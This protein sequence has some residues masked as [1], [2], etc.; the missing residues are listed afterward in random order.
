[1]LLLPEVQRSLE[2]SELRAFGARRAG[3][4]H[5]SGAPN[6]RNSK[7]IERREPIARMGTVFGVD[8]PVY[9]N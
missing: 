4:S 8:I 3:N 5:L 7:T 1:M 9:E 6:S 2:N